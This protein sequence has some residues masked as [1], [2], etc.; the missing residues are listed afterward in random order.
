M[1][2][3]QTE[4]LSPTPPARSAFA[5]WIVVG[6]GFG[7]EGKGTLT[8]WIV[9]TQG[10]QTV[11]R[12]NGGPQAGHNVTAPDGTWHCFAQFGA[13]SLVP[14]VST[15]LSRGMIVEVENLAVEA[16]V[17][18]SKGISRAASRM[19]IDPRCAVI[20]PMHKMI[21]QLLEV[22]RGVSRLGTCG[23]GVGQAAS[24]RAR[25]TSLLAGTLQ[26]VTAT[27]RAL[28]HVLQEKMP[29]AE[30]LA[31]RFPSADMA[32]L[33]QYFKTRCVPQTLARRWGE[34]LSRG[35][36]RIAEA[37]PAIRTALQQA[38][39]VFE[40]A[41]GALLDRTGGFAPF[42][43]QSDTTA[44]GAAS[45]LQSTG[46]EARSWKVGVLRAYGH[47]H[48]PGPFVTEDP[49]LA[50]R[51][52]DQRNPPNRWQGAMRFGHLDRIALRYGLARN[53]GVDSFAVTG[54]DRLTGLGVLK[55]CIEYEYDGPT[56]ALNACAVWRFA[57]NG[58]VRIS[59]LL[60]P[61][62][63]Q[64]ADPALAGI[65]MRC[66]PSR[67]IELPGWDSDLTSARTWEQLPAQ[68]RRWVEVIASREGLATPVEVV[69]VRPDAGGKVMVQ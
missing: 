35:G 6:L 64:P 23:M 65:L 8:D 21:G 9:R 67:W 47:R 15:I 32:A 4:T 1:S 58:S 25:G 62:P 38:P 49:S 22:S 28:D 19:V 3:P 43:T 50:D 11:V 41:Q 46:V 59:E 56:D 48:G 44:A 45:L 7:D 10:A 54:L 51:L 16:A 30:E 20:T 31:R 12:F 24:D 57:G 68:A 5:A 36:V 2:L 40:G 42:V 13:G 27:E 34:I 61:E 52:A 37:E 14:N 69:S 60:A 18:E 26:D 66:V 17:L 55:F 29:Q 63:G 39:V 53:G 33:L